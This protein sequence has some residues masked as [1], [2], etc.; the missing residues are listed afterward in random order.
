MWAFALVT[1]LAVFVLLAWRHLGFEAIFI[2][3]HRLAFTNDLWLMNPATD[4]IIRLMPTGFF[5]RYALSIG[6]G[7]LLAEAVAAWIASRIL[8]LKT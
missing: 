7:W 4:L 5:V 1:V 6:G 3:F 2:G 8:R